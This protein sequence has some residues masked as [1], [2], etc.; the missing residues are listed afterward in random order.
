[1]KKIVVLMMAVMMMAFI[2]S[3]LLGKDGDCVRDDTGSDSKDD[4]YI[5]GS[6]DVLFG[7]FQFTTVELDADGVFD[8]LTGG[9][10]VREH[11]NRIGRLLGVGKDC[12]WFVVFEGGLVNLFGDVNSN[13]DHMKVNFVVGGGYTFFNILRVYAKINGGG[14]GGG[15]RDYASISHGEYYN[16][17]INVSCDVIGAILGHRMTF[18]ILV[19]PH[20]G[21]GF[22]NYRLN[23]LRAG[24]HYYV[25]YSG[26]GRKEGHGIFGMEVALS[27]TFGLEVAYNVTPN[28]DVYIDATGTYVNKD[29]FDGM[30]LGKYRDGI[31]SIN[32]GCRY[33]F[34]KSA[35]NYRFTH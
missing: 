15:F 3:V 22:V 25:G 31:G 27:Y 21:L 20:V 2:P 13:Y 11:R 35:Y 16:T 8:D 14:L 10:D 29:S 6:T 9:F 24:E 26:E 1:M 18:P 30:E 32:V 17:T 23:M 5:K 33:K 4:I 34:N 7:D 19:C 12:N 28:W